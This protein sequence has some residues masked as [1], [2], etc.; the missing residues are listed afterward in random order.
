PSTTRSPRFRF[1]RMQ[2]AELAYAGISRQRDLIA[3]GEI[4]SR[5]LVELYLARINLY[6]PSLNAFRIV[7]AERALLEADQADSR[8]G[9]GALRPLLGV[10]LAVTGDMQLAGGV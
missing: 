7:F 10:P 8:R 5:E 6:E 2:P 4:S 3:A 9:A 1:R